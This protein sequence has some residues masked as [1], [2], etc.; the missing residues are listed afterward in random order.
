[1]KDL[2]K[3]YK[4]IQQHLKRAGLKPA[5]RTSQS[6]LDIAAYHIEGKYKHLSHKTG[7]TLRSHL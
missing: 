1:M 7:K 5:R 2:M 6:D 3:E 4:K